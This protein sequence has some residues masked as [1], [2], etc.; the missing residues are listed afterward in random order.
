M[1][2][3]YNKKD[4]GLVKVFFVVEDGNVISVKAGNQVVPTETGYQFYVEEHIALQI[5]KCELYME[6]FTPKLRVCDGE[7]IDIP[8]LTEKEKRKK[9]LEYEL[10]QLENAE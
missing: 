7:T 2:E 9:Q 1:I 5:D 4:F 6:G 8:Q 10:E 3:T